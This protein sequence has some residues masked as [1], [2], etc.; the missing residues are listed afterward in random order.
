MSNDRTH[1][2]ELSPYHFQLLDRVSVLEKGRIGLRYHVFSVDVNE[3]NG[4]QNGE[5]YAKLESS[6]RSIKEASEYLNSTPPVHGDESQ[7]NH[8][9]SLEIYEPSEIFSSSTLKKLESIGFNEHIDSYALAIPPRPGAESLDFSTS[10]FT[11]NGLSEMMKDGKDFHV[12]SLRGGR[13]DSPFIMEASYDENTPDDP[14][15]S[16]S[17]IKAQTRAD[18]IQSWEMRLNDGVFSYVY[19]THEL[20]PGLHNAYPHIFPSSLSENIKRQKLKSPSP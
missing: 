18:G 20:L 14:P 5:V 8:T 1:A 19:K 9:V 13:K 4:D 17:L 11:L 15:S 3:S 16:D 2:V 10:T 7:G 12:I 6:F